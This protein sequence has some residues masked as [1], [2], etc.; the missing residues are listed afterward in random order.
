MVLRLPPMRPGSFF[1]LITRDGSVPG[2]MDP[3]F[4]DMGCPWLLGRPANPWRLTTPWNPRPLVTP[5]TSHPL[6][7]LEELYVQLLAQL[8]GFVRTRLELANETRG[9]L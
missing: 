1:P 6:T 7:G 8:E 5:V 4:R 3:G 2:P 9:G